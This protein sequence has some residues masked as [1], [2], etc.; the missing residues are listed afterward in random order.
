MVS[1]EPSSNFKS[2]GLKTHQSSPLQA[3]LKCRLYRSWSMLFFVIGFSVESKRTRLI[4]VIVPKEQASNTKNCPKCETENV[5]RK[6]LPCYHEVCYECLFRFQRDA[7]VPPYSIRCPL[8]AVSKE[9]QYPA[10]STRSVRGYVTSLLVFW[11][12]N[13]TKN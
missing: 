3:M 8:G 13:Q 11:W 10:R 5:R 12:R 6:V 9:I 4:E 2:R 1:F 7:K